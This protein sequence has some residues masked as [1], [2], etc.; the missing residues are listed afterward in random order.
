MKRVVVGLS[1]GVDRRTARL[2]ICGKINNINPKTK[3]SL[4]RQRIQKPIVHS[5]I[6]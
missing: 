2:A 4:L 6:E 5:R 3:Y 1:G